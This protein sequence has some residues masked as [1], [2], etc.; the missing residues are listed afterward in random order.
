DLVMPNGIIWSKNG[1][2]LIIADPG[3]KKTYVYKIN[4]DGSPSDRELFCERGSDGMTLDNKGNLY[5]TGNGE[6]VFNN[7][8]KQ[9][10]HIK[11]PENWTAN[12]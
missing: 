2:K 11:V 10:K 5:L 9:I 8:G 7:D 3:D 4:K 6:T 12:V 1:K